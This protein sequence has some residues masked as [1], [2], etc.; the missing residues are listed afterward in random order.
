M[1]ASV[2]HRYPQAWYCAFNEDVS[3]F[4]SGCEWPVG[5]E[6]E[7]VL[8]DSEK[9]RAVPA[10]CVAG[11][12]L[13]A[14][15]SSKL[16]SW[17]Q[18]FYARIQGLSN[19]GPQLPVIFLAVLTDFLGRLKDGTP[20]FSP[21]DYLPMLFVQDPTPLTVSYPLGAIDPLGL[22]DG[23]IKT[24]ATLWANRGKTK[25]ENLSSF[26][27]GGLGMLQGRDKHQREWKTVLAYCGGTAYD[28][29][30]DGNVLLNPEARPRSTKGKCG[31]APLV[32]GV[33]ANC[34]ICGKL[35]CRACGFCSLK[36]QE[37]EFAERAEAAKVAAQKKQSEQTS[38]R[39]VANFG[40]VGSPPEWEEIPLELYEEDLRRR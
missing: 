37:H 24:L 14:A 13:P 26:R 15:I 27:F 28:M 32:I 18:D 31:N 10:L 36:C 17:Q 4:A 35:V 33:E 11:K 6:W 40:D 2:G 12:P 19:G 16:H 39:W 3:L 38:N 1:F 22:I 9:A 30:E 8:D 23:L 34:P 7:H 29:D 5:E 21:N 20:N 25:L